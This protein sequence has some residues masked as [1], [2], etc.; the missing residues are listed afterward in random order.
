MLILQDAKTYAPLGIRINAIC[1]GSVAIP[2]P[3]PWPVRWQNK[4]LCWH[5]G[6]QRGDCE[7]PHGARVSE[8]S[9]GEGC[10]YGWG[11]WHHCFH[12]VTNGK[13]HA[14]GWAT[15]GW[16]ILTIRSKSIVS[17]LNLKPRGSF[18]ILLCL[19]NISDIASVHTPVIITPA[20]VQL[21]MLV[22][23][24]AE[25]CLPSKGKEGKHIAREIRKEW[26][27][28]ATLE[29]VWACAYID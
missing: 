27:E 19:F 8:N 12:G 28:N 3:M 25:S 22:K 21:R 14:W 29:S 7:G 13:L 4:Q 20:C 16:R 26:K 11:F 6:D 24:F 17:R 9:N 10:I 5:T 23:Y 1:P 15:F 18:W 2:S